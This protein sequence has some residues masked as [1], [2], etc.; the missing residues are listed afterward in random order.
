MSRFL[1]FRWYHTGR[2]KV[3]MYWWEGTRL[4]CVS[5]M[6]GDLGV[7]SG[8]VREAA[9]WLRTSKNTDQ[10]AQPWPKPH[11]PARAHAK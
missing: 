3:T 1:R 4:P 11:P 5:A 10:W 9:E 7:V 2:I 8:L 6:P